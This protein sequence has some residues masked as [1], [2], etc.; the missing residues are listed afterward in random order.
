MLLR[1]LTLLAL[2]LILS[3]VLSHHTRAQTALPETPGTFSILGYDP[4]TGEVGGAVQSR[5][6]SVGNG[7]LWAEAGVGAARDAGD[8]RRQLRAEGDPA[9]EGRARAVRDHPC[10]PRQRF[11]SRLERTAVAEG[12]PPVRGDG[13]ERQLRGLHRARKPTAG[14][15]TRAESSA[16]RRAT[17]SPAKPSSPTWS[18]PSKPRPG[19]CRCD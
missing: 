6:F 1:R 11:R 8:R 2:P 5:V 18:R 10:D 16:P 7:V 17:S 9:A 4:D 14:P 3:F 19:I 12:G 13:R 15:A